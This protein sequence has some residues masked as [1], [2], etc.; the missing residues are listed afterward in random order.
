MNSIKILITLF[1]IST[2]GFTQS[3]ENISII[4]EIKVLSSANILKETR[5]SNV[6]F[7]TIGKNKKGDIKL[8]INRIQKS[9]KFSHTETLDQDTLRY[10][11]AGVSVDTD[12]PV[13]TGEDD[14]NILE[15]LTRFTNNSI[16]YKKDKNDNFKGPKIPGGSPNIESMFIS[17]LPVL[18][19]LPLLTSLVLNISP[20]ASAICD[21]VASE[22]YSGFFINNY[23]KVEGG[24]YISGKLI[25][26]NNQTKADDNNFAVT[27]FEFFEYEGRIETI[28]EKINTLKLNVK[29]K[30][31]VSF[32]G[33]DLGSGKVEEY[34]IISTNKFTNNL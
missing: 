26:I 1:I 9:V 14:K 18:N 28:N 31:K 11:T 13:P 5:I 4:N 3:L 23:K 16:Y 27:T 17:K 24:Y 10:E 20:N 25:P 6:E 33:M 2:S 29:S 30:S 15:N 22:E 19:K 34:N 7:Y 32:K 8:T 21:T 12:S